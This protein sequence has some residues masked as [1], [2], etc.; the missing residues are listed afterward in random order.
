MTRVEFDS[1]DSLIFF[2]LKLE[3]DWSTIEELLNLTA[4]GDPR[5]LASQI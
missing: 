3:L 1:G 2:V 5:P 4:F